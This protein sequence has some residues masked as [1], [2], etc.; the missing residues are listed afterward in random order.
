M[1]CV[2]LTAAIS[3]GCRTPIADP[4]PAIDD[5]QEPVQRWLRDSDWILRD[6]QGT[7]VT[8]ELFRSQVGRR[9]LAEAD[10]RPWVVDL[11]SGSVWR[12]P[13]REVR[14]DGD[15]LVARLAW[16]GAARPLGRVAADPDDPTALT[17]AA[18]RGQRR[19]APAPPLDGPLTAEQILDLRPAYRIGMREHAPNPRSVAAI[20]AAERPFEVTV[21][22]GSWC[23]A[24]QNFLPYALRLEFELA[25]SGA[26]WCYFALPAPPAGFRH[27]EVLRAGVR[28]LPAAVVTRDGTVLGRLSGPDAFRSLDRHLARMV[29]EEVSFVAP[30]PAGDA[31]TPMPLP[32]FQP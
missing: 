14:I 24:C 11:D 17:L 12:L 6:D 22:F 18:P 26:Q 30:V 3:W 5:G 13:R 27:P 20:R 28:E 23:P 7:P 29:S 16:P 25:R 15:R 9:L 4:R 2:L 32:A 31:G 1:G 21:L 8:G 19:L 10:R